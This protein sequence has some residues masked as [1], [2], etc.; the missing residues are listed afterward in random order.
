M[1]ENNQA[2][3]NDVVI[4]EPIE[5]QSPSTEES[6][7][8]S[9]INEESTQIDDDGIEEGVIDSEPNEQE[10][11]K[12][13]EQERFPKKAERALERR[14]KK[15]NKQRTQIA[16]L[17]RELQEYRNQTRVEQTQNVP[18]GLVKPSEDDFEDYA[19]FLKAE[20]K[21]EAQLEYAKVEVETQRKQEIESQREWVQV[22]AKQIDERAAEAVKNIPELNGLYQENQ[23][24]IEGYSDATKIAF[25]E[26]E[27]P[28]MAFYALA[29]EGKLESLDSMTPTQVARTIA[30]AEVRGEELSKTRPQSQAP[31]P[32]KPA[33]GGGARGKTLDDM[34]PSE[35]LNHLKKAK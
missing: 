19:D 1:R 31:A 13:K 17:E 9:E 28:E 22:R 20:G 26:A 24:I 11:D 34:S 3:E 25:L 7:L 8:S 29:R 14:N 2:I 16:E 27:K 10:D 12:I 33:K 35:L 30:F 15:I 23:D 5:N 4:D 18:D 21:Y 6:A 32:I